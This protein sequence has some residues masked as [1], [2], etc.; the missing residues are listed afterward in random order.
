[1]TQIINPP[2]ASPFPAGHMVHRSNSRFLVGARC[3]RP[4]LSPGVASI[5]PAMNDPRARAARPYTE[6]SNGGISAGHG[7]HR[8]VSQPQ[9]IGVRLPSSAARPPFSAGHGVHRSVSQPQTI[10]AHLPSSAAKPAFS[11]GH[12]VHRSFSVAVPGM[13]IAKVNHREHREGIPASA[14]AARNNPSSVTS[15]SSVSSVVNLSSAGHGVHRSDS[16][17]RPL[18]A[19]FPSRRDRSAFTRVRLRLDLSPPAGHG[20]LRS[21]FMIPHPCTAAPPDL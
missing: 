4:P 8:S 10:G 1:M 20:V 19:A 9:T 17:P 3:A 15:V 16:Q 12:G 18:M 6:R 13:P 14:R 2:V 5:G 21:N 11:A 7:V